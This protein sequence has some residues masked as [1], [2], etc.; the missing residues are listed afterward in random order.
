MHLNI[1]AKRDFFFPASEMIEFSNGI[2]ILKIS[3]KR[4]KQY[5]VLANIIILLYYLDT[6]F[7]YYIIL[8]YLE[9]IKKVGRAAT[10]VQTSHVHGRAGARKSAR[11]CSTRL[12]VPGPG[13]HGTLQISPF[14]WPRQAA[15][16]VYLLD[17]RHSHTLN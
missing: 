3:A 13:G 14:S 6:L 4:T 7:T 1:L 15:C 8:H 17:F 11:A 9:E 10:K 5:L 16:Y 12:P 2:E